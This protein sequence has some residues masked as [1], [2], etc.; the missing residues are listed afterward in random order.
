VREG[1][2]ERSR[3]LPKSVETAFPVRAQRGAAGRSGGGPP[4]V[5]LLWCG[6][7]WQALLAILLIAGLVAGDVSDLL[8]DPF[9]VLGAVLVMLWAV[10]AVAHRRAVGRAA[11]RIREAWRPPAD[12]GP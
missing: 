10:G 7:P 3:H 4:R 12:R 2:S 5:A 1:R 6:R 9:P 8:A 11:R